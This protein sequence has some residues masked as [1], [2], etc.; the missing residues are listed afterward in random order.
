MAAVMFPVQNRKLLHW[1]IITR[2]HRL[3]DSLT[4]LIQAVRIQDGCTDGLYLTRHEVLSSSIGM[5]FQ[6]C[7]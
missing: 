5:D 4:K 3:S 7:H 1:P 6:H 2:E